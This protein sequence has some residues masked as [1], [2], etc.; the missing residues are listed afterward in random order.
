[1]AY[2]ATVFEILIASPGDVHEER[3][4]ARQVILEW[5][6][7]FSKRAN[8]VLQ[9]RMW[10]LDARPQIGSDPQ[11]LINRQFVRDCDLVIAIFWTRL[12]TK[13]PRAD[14]GTVE[15][16]LEHANAGKPAL[17]YF[18]SRKVDLGTVDYVQYQ[19]VQAFREKLAG[20]AIL[21]SFSDL[22]DF[23]RVLADHLDSAIDS[24]FKNQKPGLL[25]NEPTQTNYLEISDKAL[26]L[27][28]GTAKSNSKQFMRMNMAIG[29]RIW[30]DTT[31]FHQ[32]ADPT[33][34]IGWTSAIQELLRAGLCR[35][36]NGKGQ[37]FELT[38]DG[39]DFLERGPHDRFNKGRDVYVEAT[40]K[41]ESSLLAAPPPDKLLKYIVRMPRSLVVSEGI[42]WNYDFILRDEGFRYQVLTKISN[43][44]TTALLDNWTGS[45]YRIESLEFYE[46]DPKSLP[47]SYRQMGGGCLIWEQTEN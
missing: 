4:A 32:E 34:A 38:Q 22:E 31:V 27:L 25:P 29:A 46:G 17:V 7:K 24:H 44:E 10:E 9:P 2:S 41:R 47:S 23:K 28:S 45:S 35:D 26:A 39:L 19:A 16:I 3:Q 11:E 14:S 42:E 1:M 8:I 43:I 13:T 33:A 37:I 20:G 21:W 18:S 5:N 36:I 15:E 30:S 40:V 6:R 12:G